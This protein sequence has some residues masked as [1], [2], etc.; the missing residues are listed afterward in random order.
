MPVWK[1]HSL[2]LHGDAAGSAVICP[3]I[4]NLA[5]SHNPE[6]TSDLV[7]NNGRPLFAGVK[8]IKPVYSGETFAL[9]TILDVI[10]VFGLGF[11]GATNPGMVYY[12][13]KFDDAGDASGAAPSVVGEPTAE[14]LP[15][16]PPQATSSNP[17]AAARNA[18]REIGVSGRFIMGKKPAHRVV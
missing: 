2:K 12:F 11:T 6:F 9:P 10:G 13:Q 15:L 4:L 14:S 16:P 17:A 5:G 3:D 8:S 1:P 18:E 7:A